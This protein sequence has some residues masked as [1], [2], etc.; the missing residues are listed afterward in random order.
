MESIEPYYWTSSKCGRVGFV[1]A[2]FG[3]GPRTAANTIANLLNVSLHPWE[4][5]LRKDLAAELK[6]SLFLNF[7]VSDPSYISCS[8]GYRVWV[9]CLMWLRRGL[10]KQVLAYDLFLAE[11]F[12]ELQ[13]NILPQSSALRVVPPLYDSPNVSARQVADQKGHILVSFGGVETPFTKA[14]HRY[15]FPERILRALIETACQLNDS[16]KIICCMPSHICKRLSTLQDLRLV[17]FTSPSRDRFLKLLSDA[18]LYIV[19]PGLYGPCE[20]F[21]YRVPTL[22]MPPF[23]YTQLC[24]AKAYDRLNLLGH[25]PLWS[26]LDKEFGHLMGDIET[27]EAKSFELLG[28]WLEAHALRGSSQQ[29]FK[30]WTK[31]AMKGELISDRLVQRRADYVRGFEMHSDSYIATLRDLIC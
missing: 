30:L 16:R 9:D 27:E 6:P 23:S 31:A 3:Y 25:V 24:Q 20:A 18:S 29:S 2:P 13:E 4:S 15:L 12:F 28:D 11:S 8:S 17:H 22:F 1:I 7:G 26:E 10:P 19:Q 14:V 5:Y 21:K